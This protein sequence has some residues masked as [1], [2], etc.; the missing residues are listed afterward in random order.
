MPVAV[1]YPADHPVIRAQTLILRPK[2]AFQAR[3]L[4]SR[5]FQGLA[6]IG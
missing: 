6:Q 1:R 2:N 4:V 3:Q 5:M